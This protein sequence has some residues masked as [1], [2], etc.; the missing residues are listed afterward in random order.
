MSVQY[1]PYIQFCQ[2]HAPKNSFNMQFQEVTKNTFKI[3]SPHRKNSPDREPDCQHAIVHSM[4]DITST[5]VSRVI[6]APPATVFQ[7]FLDQDAVATWLPPGEMRGVIHA[8]EPREGGAF[9]MS[10]VYPASDKS[11]RGKTSASTD[12][13]QGRFVKLIPNTQIVWAVRFKSPDPAFAGEMTVK[14][15]LAS[16]GTGTMVTMLCENV[17][18]AYVPKTTRRAPARRSKNLPHFWVDNTN[19]RG[20]PFLS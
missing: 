14:T 12:T 20:S 5:E 17:P 1:S 7:A 2:V 19:A 4:S 10:L 13:F 11:A 15:T 9:S 16:A 8:F 6:N 18:P 3:H